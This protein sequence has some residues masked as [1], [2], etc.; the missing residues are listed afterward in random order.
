[1]PRPTEQPSHRAPASPPDRG[2]RDWLI[3]LGVAAVWIGGARLLALF[4]APY[5]PLAVRRLLTLQS[6]LSIIMVVTCAAGLGLAFWLLRRPREDLG[7][8]RAGP[9]A[10]VMAALLS[11]VALVLSLYLAYQL[12]LPAIVAEIAAGGRRAAELH[13]GEFGRSLRQTHA[14]TTVLWAVVLAPMGEEL[15]F[16]GVLWSLV[17]RLTGGFVT[18]EQE[19]SLP[20]ELIAEGALLRGLR[21]GGRWLLAGGIATI[22][23]TAIFAWMH[24]DQQGGAGVV[25]VIQAACLGLLLGVIRHVTKSIGPAAICHGLFNAMSLAKLRKW[26]VT[27]GWPESK[28]DAVILGEARRLTVTMPIPT[29]YWHVAGV[30][31]ALLLAWAVYAAIRPRGAS[32]RAWL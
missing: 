7:L 30:C 12:A 17:Q 13:T 18:K 3:L 20:P 10:F 9:R 31:L 29:W 16:R 5:W 4:S 14:V 28:V 25:R 27:G 26:I 32:N 8:G 11:P 24:A 21:A 6:Y 19:R 22:A 2:W 15:M 23:T 1:M